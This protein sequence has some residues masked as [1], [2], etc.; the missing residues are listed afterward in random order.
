MGYGDQLL[1]R[2]V[3]SENFPLVISIFS[4]K[5]EASHQPKLCELVCVCVRRGGQFK[6]GKS[7]CKILC[8]QWK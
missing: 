1:C 6:G 2:F 8:R 5:H 4:R 7:R 3:M